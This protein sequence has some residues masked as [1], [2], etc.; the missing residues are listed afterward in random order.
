[1]LLALNLG[2]WHQILLQG[3]RWRSARQQQHA[4]YSAAAGVWWTERDA[5]LL[6]TLLASELR[7]LHHRRGRCSALLSPPTHLFTP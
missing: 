7:S 4:R 1:M 5:A 6:E 2:D 3:A